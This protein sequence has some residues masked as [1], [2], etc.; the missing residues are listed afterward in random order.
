MHEDVFRKLTPDQLAKIDQT[1]LKIPGPRGHIALVDAYP[2][3]T[4][5]ETRSALMKL[6][7]DIRAVIG[8][9]PLPDGGSTKLWV[10]ASKS[11][12]H[13]RQDK[14]VTE[15]LH[16]C[17]KLFQISVEKDER[18]EADY[19]K[20]RVFWMGKLIAH[21]KVDIHGLQFRLETLKQL[22]NTITQER[23]DDLRQTVK[24]EREARLDKM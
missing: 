24:K 18:L 17:R 3:A 4:P 8:E 10:S 6:V 20:G 14:D 2:L 21:R 1:T 13:R 12:E 11:P 22:D 23:L 16:V 19:A 5:K 9:I 15:I 7:K